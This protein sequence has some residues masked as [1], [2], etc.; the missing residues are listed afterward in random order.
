MELEGATWYERVRQAGVADKDVQTA[1]LSI[2]SEQA[3]PPPPAPPPVLAP[4]KSAAV[5]V[6]PAAPA[7]PAFFYRATNAVSVTIRQIDR[8]G[9]VIGAAFAA[10]ANQAGGVL[11]RAV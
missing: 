3:V 10:G 9:A 6:A 8:A 7:L 11:G 2:Y 5:A 1:Q 4:G